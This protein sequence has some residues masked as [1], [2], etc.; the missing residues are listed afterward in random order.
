M[1]GSITLMDRGDAPAQVVIEKTLKAQSERRT[2]ETKEQLVK[3]TDR[4]EQVREV[5]VEVKSLER[6]CPKLA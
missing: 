5:I 2:E 3:I 4:V 6:W 1:W